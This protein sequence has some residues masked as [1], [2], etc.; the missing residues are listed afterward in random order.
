MLTDDQRQAIRD[1][2]D[3]RD[4]YLEFV[5][6]GIIRGKSCRCP[7]PNHDD[8]TPSASIDGQGWHCHA[9][10]S[11]GDAIAM[12]QLLTGCTFSEATNNVLHRLGERLQ[13]RTLTLAPS[14]LGLYLRDTTKHLVPPTEERIE[15]MRR[16]W[17]IVAGSLRKDSLCAAWLQSRGLD[18]TT[19]EELGCTDWER[20]AGQL[21]ESMRWWPAELKAQSG[22]FDA[23]RRPWFPLRSIHDRTNSGV[24]IPCH[25]PL[26]PWPI[27]WR[28]RWTRPL[29]FA[30]RT[31]KTQA[32]HGP[33]Y[34]VGLRAHGA[35]TPSAAGASVV[36]IAEGE[37]DWLSLHTAFSRSDKWAPELA[38]IGICDVSSGLKAEVVDS[39]NPKARVILCTH[40]NAAA[41]T[42]TRDFR[43]LVPAG[44]RKIAL[45]AE[46]HDLND[47]LQ[48][49]TLN[50]WIREVLG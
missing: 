45:V 16:V 20:V 11:R 3:V 10:G 4:L 19:A 33:V 34:P 14:P 40:N 12:V 44:R 17:E 37:P 31:V 18:V 13:R 23:D 25:H 27:S 6:N 32:M 9:C 1:H 42:I 5:P 36:F 28:W 38:S 15:A 47:R 46:S 35:F 21:A 30:E 50:D 8:V 24:A 7:D 43:Q 41:E 22:L 49:G 48:A 39:I 26:C 29:R 2:V